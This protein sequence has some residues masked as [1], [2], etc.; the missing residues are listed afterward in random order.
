MWWS[1]FPMRIWVKIEHSETQLQFRTSRFRRTTQLRLKQLGQGEWN[2]NV[3]QLGREAFCTRWPRK[4]SVWTSVVLV[5]LS[6]R[7]VWNSEHPLLAKQ[8]ALKMRVVDS[9]L[10]LSIREERHNNEIRMSHNCIPKS[11]V[12]TIQMQDVPIW[13][14]GHGSKISTPTMDDFDKHHAKSLSVSAS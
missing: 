2:T 14:Y 5:Y 4:G 11:F 13:L 9:S 12:H 10:S 3:A 7:L 1:N 6:S 8:P